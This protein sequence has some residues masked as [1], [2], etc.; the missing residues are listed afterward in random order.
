MPSV[1]FQQFLAALEEVKHLGTAS[2]PTLA[3]NAPE[4]LSLAR[5]VGRGQIVLLSSHFERYFYAVNE[6]LVGFLNARQ[7]NG[8]RLPV[9]V[10]LLHSAV[11]V[12]D[13]NKTGWE[14]RLDKLE[15]FVAE[16]GW[17]WTQNVP[18]TLLHERLL[19]WMKAPKPESLVRYYRYWGVNDIFTA[20]TRNTNTRSALWLGVRG[21]VELRNN[22]AH[23][24]FAAQATQADLRR[25]MAQARQFCER[26]DRILATQ[27]GRAF[28]VPRPW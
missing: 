28:T 6:E 13:L 17:L 14:R 1:A 15:T 21:L 23:G 22:I 19:V 11:P 25:Y 4:S 5:A 12:D 18:G 26:A 8:S 9:D 2:H 10:R 3:P 7:L 16:D 24:D 20:A 27:I